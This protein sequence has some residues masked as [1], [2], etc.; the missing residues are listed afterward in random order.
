MNRTYEQILDSM[1]SEY[2]R[3]CDTVAED[4]S[5]IMRCFEILAS[6]LFS[7]SCYGDYIFRQAFIQ[8]ASGDNLDK[9]GELRGCVRKTASKASGTLNFSISLPSETDII[10]P[11]DTVCSV[12]GKPYLQYATADDGVIKAGELEA[13]VTAVSLDTGDEYNV[14]PNTIT[15]MVNAPIG[16]TAVTNKDSFDGGYTA[17]SDTAYRDRILR[18]YNIE[19]NSINAVSN[20]NRI[21]TLD[22]VVDCSV[23]PR[24]DSSGMM[25]YVATKSNTLSSS[26]KTDIV[27]TLPVLDSTGIKYEI[28]LAKRLQFDLLVNAHIM[29]GFDEQKIKSEIKDILLDV[30]SAVRINESIP[31][32]RLTKAVS[33]VSG[34]IDVS[35]YTDLLKGDSIVPNEFGVLNAADIEVSCIYD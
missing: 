13:S 35:F 2:F 22:F 7:L 17:E 1:K 20:E 30:I 31:I 9:A 12:S 3:H 5:Q 16:V 21:L 33:D 27:Y 26:E 15:V 6:E 8:S 24:S 19:P 4:G 23:V 32:S 34:L 14:K 10:I 11:K 29:T 25:I 18:H 28:E